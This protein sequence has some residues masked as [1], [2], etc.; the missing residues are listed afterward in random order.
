MS[1]E[2]YLFIKSDKNSLF[3]ACFKPDSLYRKEAY[4][5]CHPFA[6]EK[7]YTQK[8]LVDLAKKLQSNGI[9]AI[10]FDLN[11]C[12]DSEGNLSNSSV[13]SWLRDIENISLY[14]RNELHINNINFIGLR[15]STYLG[16]LSIQKKVAFK[17]IIMI[18]PVFNG[19]SYLH[20]TIKNKRIKK[21]FSENKTLSNSKQLLEEL[22]NNKSIDFDGNE[23]S[24]EFYINLIEN[25]K[26]FN[27]Q[28]IILSETEVVILKLSIINKLFREISE[29]V[30]LSKSMNK[31]IQYK[32][33]KYLP[34]WNN[35]QIKNHD[36]IIQGVLKVS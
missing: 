19:V 18:E 34:F 33:I 14:V 11:G 25:Q 3:T 20:K 23:I 13:S 4:I 10:L 5:I 35:N 21:F 30:D 12:G 36:T 2:E 29:F 8:L 17:K 31:E 1:L 16:M 26:N 24:S 9:T 27:L 6:E 32:Q 28:D 7:K 22:I 15:F